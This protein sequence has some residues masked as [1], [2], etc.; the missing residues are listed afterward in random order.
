MASE[1][2]I[3]SDEDLKAPLDLGKSFEKLADIFD[4]VVGSATKLNNELE[5]GAKS[6][7]EQRKAS[8][9]L[10]K[11]QK[12]LDKA[13]KKAAKSQKDYAV[14]T[15][16]AD[17]ATNGM[18]SRV[19]DLVKSFLV[20]L[21]NP[22]GAFFLVVAGALAA[23][24]TYFKT[25]NEGAD[26]LDQIL[27]GLR[28][29]FQFLIN[30]VADLG[31]Q[32]VEMFSEGTALGTVFSF[33]FDQI[34]NRVSAT[35]D[36]F[37]SLL[38]IIGTLSK[39]NLKDLLTGNL[40]AADLNELKDATVALGKAGYQAL[41]GIGDAADEAK[42]KVAS[43]Q[44]LTAA[45]DTLGDETRDRILSKAQALL[46]V[47]KLVFAAKDKANKS[48]Q[49]R[50]DAARKAIE[51]SEE[52]LKIDKDLAVRRERL[53]TAELLHRTGIINS[54][55]E[56]NRVLQHGTTLLQDQ[57]LE[58]KGL[59]EELEKRRTLQAA[60][61]D[62]ERAFFAENKR[63][64]SVIGSLQEEIDRENIKNAERERDIRIRIFDE[65][66]AA[67]K[68]VSGAE[69]LGLRTNLQMR[70][71]LQKGFNQR[72]IDDTKARLE[73]EKEI[74]KLKTEQLAEE[75]AKRRE[76]ENTLFVSAQAAQTAVL[77][78][79]EIKR[80]KAD[81][82]LALSEE[83]RKKELAGAEGDA[84]KTLAVNRKFDREQ[85]KI[86]QKQAKSEK[87]AALFNILIATAVGIA[88]VA[89]NPVLIALTAAIGAIQAALVASKPLP[90]FWKGTKHAPDSFIAG[91]RGRELVSKDGKGYIAEKPTIFTGMEGARVFNKKETDE[92]LGD[93]SDVGYALN[94]GSRVRPKVFGNTLVADRLSE[95][96]RWL[97]RIATRPDTSL[98][99]DET[100]F[101]TYLSKAAKQNSRI[102]RRFR[103]R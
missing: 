62:A 53:F 36:I 42:A 59:D 32:I 17:A 76:L 29:V 94:Y 63:N 55:E 20:L 65:Q 25:T 66:L 6:T 16:K 44:A 41:T 96:N 88:K 48:D 58:Q 84:R 85:A 12:D 95:S 100:G 40:T 78:F 5:G 9:E 3:I 21:A 56:A 33:I 73:K 60:V 103:G 79:V 64:I 46:D 92:V 14:A 30:K 80:N 90:K 19:K 34:I 10:E 57:L 71:S 52:Q 31:K 99:I 13:N 28:G 15:E 8:A 81:E 35:I 89:P 1:L 11:T 26:K 24:G 77:A 7:K 69:I 83:R 68:T 45:G 82:D 97:K 43:L 75:I 67:A 102:D 38:R 74:E 101:H 86:K 91:D 47:E 93:A 4:K 49:E 87:D 72:L 23:V 27:A 51:L 54:N 18:V 37:S 2:N 70:E 39:Y 61:F 22:I 98:V 50:L